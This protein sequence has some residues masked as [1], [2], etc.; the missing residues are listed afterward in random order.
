MA[1]RYWV[2]KDATGLWSDPDAWGSASGVED[3]A[4]VPT[5]AD[6][7]IY[8]GAAGN[9]QN[10]C[11]LDAAITCGA[12]DQQAG[13][14]GTI[15]GA[16]DN[17]NHSVTD[18]NGETGNM[19]LDGT[20][21]NNGSG[22]WTVEGDFDNQHVAMAHNNGH[23]ELNGTGKTLT[24][25]DAAAQAFY[26]LTISGTITTAGGGCYVTTGG[27][28]S[29]SGTLDVAAGD[30]A[31]MNRCSVSI[32]GIVTGDG[33]MI[34]DNLGAA[35]TTMTGTLNVATLEF[36]RTNQNPMLPAAQYDSAT[37]IIAAYLVGLG[38]YTFK[39][40]TGTTTFTGNVTFW[41]HSAASTRSLVVDNSANDPVHLVFEGDVAIEE[42]GAG[43]VTWT[44][45]LNGSILFSGSNTQNVDFLGKAVEDIIINKDAGDLIL[46]GNVITDSFTGT[47]TGTGAFDPNGQTIE[48][49]DGA[50]GS[51]D[52]DWAADFDFHAAADTMNGCTWTVDGD[53]TADGQTL[54]ATAGWDLDVAGT[55]VASG[56]G[57]V[58]KSTA[59]GT[60]ITATL[61]G[62]IGNGNTNW[63]FVVVVTPV[64]LSAI[65]RVHAGRQ[66]LESYILGLGPVGYWRLNEVS[67]TVALDIGSG[68]NNGTYTGGVTLGVKSPIPPRVVGVARAADCDGVDNYILVGDKT[69]L[70]FSTQFSVAAWVRPSDIIGNQ[71]VVAKY[72]TTGDER[73]WQFRLNTAKLS[74]QFGD[75]ADGTY[76]GEY[77]S[78]DDLVVAGSWQH[79]G[80]TYNTGSVILYYNGSAK[81]GGVIDNVP[82]SLYNGTADFTI[83]SRHGGA[84]PYAGLV[85]SVPV[86]RRV[87][88]PSEFEAIY[89]IGKN[90]A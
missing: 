33:R 64:V 87:L 59:G 10:D 88:T 61:W 2:D 76:E 60:A 18:D 74:V 77:Q 13:Y 67:G 80:M 86:Y 50:G 75:P 79:I 85:A 49:D 27:T 34:M 78:N 38:T 37:V 89:L 24:S 39:F 69:S 65:K 58:Q 81:A 63:I 48:T 30:N 62:E 21:I 6:K 9:P 28:A 22:K 68:G 90:G 72:L 5:N 71:I 16:S 46:D 29:I 7:A 20:Q 55:A 57:N 51:G 36:R 42:N 44:K 1:D 35:I 31:V 56:T 3:S 40:A 8:D 12:I 25:E 32:T 4:G 53:F 23:V 66:S 70:E 14:T 15:D 52:C 84:A 82:S 11:R 83:G 41:N 17:L 43:T 26:D 54:N 45:S 73:E 47:D 19:I